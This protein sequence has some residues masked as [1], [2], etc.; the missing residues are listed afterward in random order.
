[1]AQGVQIF[2]SYLKNVTGAPL[3]DLLPCPSSRGDLSTH[4]TGMAALSP[5]LVAAAVVAYLGPLLWTI[6]TLPL[7]ELL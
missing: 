3:A 6:L 2:S 7:V 4:L 5:L 1:M